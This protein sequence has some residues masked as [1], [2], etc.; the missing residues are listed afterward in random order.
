MS[1]Q[2]QLHTCT[3][4]TSAAHC[5]M[6]VPDTHPP[7]L[8]HPPPAHAG[9]MPRIAPSMHY[10]AMLPYAALCHAVRHDATLMTDSSTCLPA[11]RALL[12]AKCSML[13]PV[14]PGH[15][16]EHLACSNV[17]HPPPPALPTPLHLPVQG[18]AQACHCTS[19]PLHYTA[20]L[21]CATLCY[22]VSHDAMA[23]LICLHGCPECT[24]AGKVLH[25]ATCQ[26]WQHQGA[27]YLQ[28]CTSARLR[29]P[30]PPNTSTALR[31]TTRRCV[32]LYYI[33][34]AMLWYVMPCYIHH[35]SS[36]SPCL[37]A[38]LSAC[39]PACNGSVCYT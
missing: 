4:L 17:R 23:C 36:A 39:L 10:T 1:D 33:Y 12:L 31:C 26:Y 25:V 29:L 22:A 19:L 28:Q 16:R 9:A 32:A 15:N 20:M 27:P 18:N 30:T 21:R 6:A 24:A 5:S 37:P 38:C 14:T 7:T 11:G 35:T 34:T 3:T 8:A 2:S 13:P